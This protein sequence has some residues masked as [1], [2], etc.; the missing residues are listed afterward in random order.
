MGCCP[1][2]F[3][4][5]IPIDG[6]AEPTSIVLNDSDCGSGADDGMSCKTIADESS[7]EE[8]ADEST[9][10]EASDESGDEE[11]ADESGNEEAADESGDE[12]AHD[13]SSANDEDDTHIP[14]GNHQ[15]G[16]LPVHD[17][18]STMLSAETIWYQTIPNGVKENVYFTIQNQA[19]RDSRGAKSDWADDSGAWLRKNNSTP[20]SLYVV[21]N[22]HYQSVVLF[23]GEYC[24]VRQKDKETFKFL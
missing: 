8:V 17:I 6:A 5:L 9:D 15:N 14:N 18:V 12:E 21:A 4:P 7:V 23:K 11:A 10:E 13:E 20:K 22:G 3:V 1:N 19:N 2:H 16:F 24:T